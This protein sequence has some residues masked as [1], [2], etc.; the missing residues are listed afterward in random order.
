MR[1]PDSL[2]LD[3]NCFIY[4]FEQSDRPRGRFLIEDVLLPATRG[5]RRLV[6]SCLVLAE[7][8]VQ[9]FRLGHPERA[10]ALSRAVESLPG[11]VLLPVDA[12]VAADAARL[13]GSTGLALPDALVLAT[14]TGAGAVL[15]TNDRALAH[16]AGTD[17][18]LLLDDLLSPGQSPSG[19]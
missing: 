2:A 3:T 14:A 10:A 18:A 7:L 19:R 5:E 4:L 17:A 12:R 11:L 1:L 13:R 8:L 6:T 15:L 16:A 9:P